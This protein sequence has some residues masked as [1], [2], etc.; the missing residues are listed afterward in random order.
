V[1]EN[2]EALLT[3][4][5]KTDRSPIKDGKE[6]VKESRKFLASFIRSQAALYLEP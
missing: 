3:K 4:A 2:L 5:F 1:K 6:I